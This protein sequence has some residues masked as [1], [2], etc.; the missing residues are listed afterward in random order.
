MAMSG[1]PAA[2]NLGF[3]RAHPRACYFALK[4]ESAK[5]RGGDLEGRP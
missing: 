4:D 5:D 2:R 1:V 3:S